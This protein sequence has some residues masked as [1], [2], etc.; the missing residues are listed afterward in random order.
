L[1]VCV[2]VKEREREGERERERERERKVGFP[3]NGTTLYFKVG[4]LFYTTVGYNTL[5]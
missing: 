5:Q 2:Y 4:R 1:C 3:Q